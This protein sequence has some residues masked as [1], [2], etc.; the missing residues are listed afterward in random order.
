MRPL[1]SLIS[2][3]EAKSL[4]EENI[5]TIAVKQTVPLSRCLHRVLAEEI[6]SP[7]AIPPYDRAAMDGYAVKAEDSFGAGKFDPVELESVGNVHAGEVPES[8]V[9]S[10]KCI[11]I[12]TGA[13]MP[14]GAD[15]VVKVE[16]TE[17]EGNT[18]KIFTPLYPGA[19]V[20]KKGEDIDEDER[21]F[22]PGA[23]LTPSKVGVLAA[24]GRTEVKAYNTPTVSIIPTGDEVA[25]VGSELRPGQIF[26]INSHTLSSILRENG[27]SP[28]IEPI[29]EDTE[30]AVRSALESVSDSDMI[31]LSGGSSAGERDV[32]E[33]VVSDMGEVIF[34][35]VQIKP[36][37]PTLFGRIG[38]TPLFGMP[39]YPTACLTNGYV[40][41]VDA[42]RKMARLPPKMEMKRRMP[43]AK[44]F[45]ARLGR[46]QFLTVQIRDGEAY[47]VFKESGTITSIA[48]ADGWIRIPSNVDLLEK[49]TEVEV[50]LF[51]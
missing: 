16:D 12:A 3:E 17:S 25:P 33:D 6:I 21:V 26:D 42:A 13:V 2:L 19:N 1:R 32:L 40:F 15:A 14:E 8:G 27:C 10:G 30:E 48:Y 45:P 18:I 41:L 5:E 20:S 31:V 24:I 7:L 36:G 51:Q 38:D 47:P 29:V 11:Q 44:K 28:S 46:D 49:G 37:K 50:R 35:G 22:Q 43:L 4:V 9:E 23:Y 39:G 34:H